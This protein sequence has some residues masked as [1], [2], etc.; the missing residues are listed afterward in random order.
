MIKSPNYLDICKK[1]G[2]S[3]CKGESPVVSEK[4]KKAIL[5][6]GHEDHFVKLENNLYRIGSGGKCPYLNDDFSCDIQEVKPETCKLW[7][8]VPEYD[9]ERE[10]VFIMVANCKLR[11]ELSED[12]VEKAKQKAK[13][14]PLEIIKKS[15]ELPEDS[16]RINLNLNTI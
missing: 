5:N 10:K 12:E 3:C 11:E 8:V 9:R 1:C 6:S 16:H 2:A 14:I 7:P 13:D 15:G 4:K